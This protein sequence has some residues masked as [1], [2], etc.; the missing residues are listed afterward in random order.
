MALPTIFGATYFAFFIR[1]PPFP[2]VELWNIQG[3]LSRFWA[4][5]YQSEKKSSPFL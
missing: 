5:L 2:P 4:G 3:I 1:A